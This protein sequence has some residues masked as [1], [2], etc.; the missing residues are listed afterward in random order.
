MV[1]CRLQ[2]SVQNIAFNCILLHS[3]VVI[4][5][6]I[7]FSDS[8]FYE[9]R[10]M[11]QSKVV[12]S[13]FIEPMLGLLSCILLYVGA[14]RKNKYLLLPF[15]LMMTIFQAFLVVALII[16]AIGFIF[17]GPG[18]ILVM[19]IP[20]FILLLTLWMSKTTLAFYN[21]ICED[22][23]NNRIR[24][25]ANIATESNMEGVRAR[26]V[27]GVVVNTNDIESNLCVQVPIDTNLH[28][29]FCPP[30]RRPSSEEPPPTYT[31]CATTEN[32][33]AE[34]PPSYD[35]ALALKK[36]NPESTV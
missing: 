17:M 13:I 7:I 26:R 36:Q 24:H 16:C 28:W 27:A 12:I 14:K 33:E 31:A 19:V 32:G 2:N 29:H 25:I 11:F 20:F 1:Q 3:I 15:M 10:K 5:E 34:L 21:K 35:E 6:V 8:T 18:V 23:A 9:L 30:P 4:G 22:Y